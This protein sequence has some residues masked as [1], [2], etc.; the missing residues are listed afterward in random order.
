MEKEQEDCFVDEKIKLLL[1]IFKILIMVI[2]TM[3]IIRLIEKNYTQFFADILFFVFVVFGYFRLKTD[4]SQYKTIT[5]M[6][7]FLA[8]II[9]I[10]VLIH[11]PENP[12]RF[13]WLST[14]IYMVFYLF[15]RRESIYWISTIGILL[16]LFFFLN[17]EGF[18]ITIVNFLIWIMN[19]LIVL[20]IAHWYSKIEEESTKRLLKVKDLLSTEVEIKTRE[21]EEKKNELEKKTLELQFLNQNLEAKIQ[22]ESEKNREQEKML[23]RQAKY[24]Q[25]GEMISMIAHQWRQPL[26][27]ISA[28]TATMQLKIDMEDY[29][30]ILFKNKT[31]MIAKY[32]Q[33]LSS[34]IDDFRNFFKLDKEKEELEFPKIVDDALK[35]VNSALENKHIT[36]VTEHCCS[37]RI[38]TYPNEIIHVIL[39]LVKNAEDALLGKKIT[40]PRIIIRTFKKENSVYM[41]IEDNAG[42]IEPSIMKKIFDPY[43]TTKKNAD[44]TGLGLYMSKIIIEDHCYGEI[45]VSNGKEGAVF[46]LFFPVPYEEGANRSYANRKS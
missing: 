13:I 42:G 6:I 39:N 18:N 2:G 28:A 8:I 45:E 9:S 46:R 36:V 21:L 34:T 1:K 20:M 27:A 15:E 35:L 31:L 32:I 37:C 29:E 25:M 5:R 23:F 26:N 7:F 3:S 16:S 19:M 24:A 40:D 30:K 4:F 10:Y 38:Y 44:G 17:P 22:E 12:I 14:V 41:E 43:F 11:Q 33:H